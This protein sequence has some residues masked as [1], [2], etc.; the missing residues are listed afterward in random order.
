MTR[1]HTIGR[2]YRSASKYTF[3]RPSE[4][5]GVHLCTREPEVPSTRYERWNPG[6]GGTLARVVPR[7][8]ARCIYSLPSPR[9][10]DATCASHGS[11]KAGPPAREIEHKITL[12]D[13]SETVSISFHYILHRS[14]SLDEKLVQRR[15]DVTSYTNKETIWLD[16]FPDTSIDALRYTY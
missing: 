13:F 11:G 15:T 8:V 12:H 5:I 9:G 14:I 6:K 7:P 10:R 4:I 3:A 2:R 16:F 1:L